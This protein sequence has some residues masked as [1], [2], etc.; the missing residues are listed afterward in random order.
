M[1]PTLAGRMSSVLALVDRS[2]ICCIAASY[3]FD[4]LVGAHE[5]LVTGEAE[6]L[7]CL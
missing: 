1:A 7:R 5:L 3:L 4:H 2:Q 6:C